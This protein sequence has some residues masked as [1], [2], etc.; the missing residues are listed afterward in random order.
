M[1]A[2]IQSLPPI[3][4][5][6]LG[7]T[8]LSIE[9]MQAATAVLVGTGGGRLVAELLARSAIGTLIIIDPDTVDGTR[10]PLTQGHHWAEHGEP[11]ART[12]A[13]AC[14]EINPDVRTIPLCV[15]WEK[16]CDCEGDLIA[17]ANILVACTDSYAVNRAVRQYGLIREI[18]V[19]EGWIYPDGD[20]CEHVTTFPE[21]VAAGGGCGTC[22][23]WMRHRAYEEGFQNPRDIPTYAIP[24]AYSS[25]QTA[26]IVISRLHQRAGSQLPIVA[27]A[28]QFRSRPAQI[29]RLNPHFWASVG[30]P[31]G[32]T[33]SD[34]A[35]FMT[36]A[37]DKDW[38]DDWQCP[39][40]G[41]GNSRPAP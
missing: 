1:S 12:T 9:L 36:R 6:R 25:V 13:M 15:P 11:K 21:V 40:C 33:P 41:G 17:S 34:Y 16:A 8:T 22:H 2:R 24:S 37:F 19:V 26:Q 20:A 10:N 38:P 4:Y 30:E 7:K 32:D 39:D 28:T 23:L 18:D 35:T 31:F 27:L 5:S 14:N 29:T 3:N